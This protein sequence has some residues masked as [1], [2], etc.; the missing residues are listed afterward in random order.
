M[1]DV[2]KSAFCQDCNIAIDETT[3]TEGRKPC[4]SCGSLRRRYEDSFS[5][6]ATAGSLVTTKAYKGGLSKRKG[7]RFESKDGDSFSFD[8][9]RFVELN[10]LVDH[11]NN[12]Y[13]KKVVDRKTGEAI[14][15]VDEPLTQHQE[16]G[17]AKKRDP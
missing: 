5:D 14:R 8:R 4:P 12:R 11:E 13:V 2:I 15:D 7:L 17:S 10:Q 16:R 9:Q 1:S 6:S 3:E